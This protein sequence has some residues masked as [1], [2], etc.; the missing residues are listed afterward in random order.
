MRNPLHFALFLVAGLSFVGCSNIKGEAI[1]SSNHDQ[2]A[3]DVGKSNLSDD[4]KR[5]FAAAI[6]RSTFGGTSIDGKTVGDA[7]SDQKKWQID[8]DAQAAAAHEQQ[9]KIEAE[10]DAITEEMDHAVSVQPISKRFV[11]ADYDAERFDASQYVTFQYHN[12]GSRAIK[13]IK[14]SVDFT[15]TFGDKVIN[16]QIE[17][18][19]GRGDTN[20]MI[21]P[22]G[23]VTSE[24]SWKYDPYEDEWKTFRGTELS[25]MKATWVPD[26]ILF[27]DGTSLKA[28]DSE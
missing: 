26:Q 17:D 28:P 21:P 1:T 16:L 14:G 8:Q 3:T 15:N 25:S 5:T 9:A 6:I 13:A 23:V 27:T 2:V 22:G 4:E 12:L 11:D 7:I 10:R 20:G 18:E 24:M 19:Q